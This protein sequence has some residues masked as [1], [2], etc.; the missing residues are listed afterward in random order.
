M[1]AQQS[2]SKT[3]HLLTDNNH[4]TELHHR[5]ITAPPFNPPVISE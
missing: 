3:N 2:T 1:S 4:I 5:I